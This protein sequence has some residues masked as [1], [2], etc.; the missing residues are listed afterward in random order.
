MGYQ[1]I[2]RSTPNDGNGDD[3]RTWAGKTNENMK[4]LH[5][6]AFVLNDVLVSRRSHDPNNLHFDKFLV[7]DRLEGWENIGSKTRWVEGIVLSTT[8]PV[9]SSDP[10]VWPTDIDNEAKFM[11]IDDINR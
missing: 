8:E 4:E 11:I 9:D 1:E 3:A 7:D 6:R 10:F 2:N 5:S